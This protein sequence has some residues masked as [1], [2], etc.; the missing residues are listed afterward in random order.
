MT[1]II[2]KKPIMT[3]KSLRLA[4][5]GKYSFEVDRYATKK[6]IADAVHKEFQV[7]VVSVASLVMKGK[8]KRVG[9]LRREIKQGNWKKAVVSLQKEQ[10]IAIFD[11]GK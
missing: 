1:S 6:A 5:R 2:L 10:K 11:V 4:S 7:D 9:K 3:E 8:T